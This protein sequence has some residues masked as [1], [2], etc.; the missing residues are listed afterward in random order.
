MQ[1]SCR[2]DEHQIAAIGLG[3]FDGVVAH[4]C[5]SLPRL[6]STMGT[7]ARRDHSSSCSIAAAR[8]VSAE[9]RITLRPA[10]APSLASL[11]TVVV[12]PAPLMPTNRT[13]A[14]SPPNG[15]ASA[16]ANRACKLII[17]A[18]E[19]SICIGQRLARG[20]V[21]QVFDDLRCCRT[22]HVGQNE[23][24]FQIVPKI[25]VQ[26]RTAIEQD[27]HLLGEFLARTRKALADSIKESHE[28]ALSCEWKSQPC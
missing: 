14:A 28:N 7:F 9:P 19:H 23:R 22:A 17:Q 16:V 20:F 27:V 12:L 2:V 26:I 3:A 18:I 1:A 25:V 15:S 5:R 4:A 24:F 11:P 8:N 6:R 13:H 10:S 21:A